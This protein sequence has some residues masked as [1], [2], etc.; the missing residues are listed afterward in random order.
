MQRKTLFDMKLFG[1]IGRNEADSL[2]SR[3]VAEAR[4]KQSIID[5]I[6]AESLDRAKAEVSKWRDAL[7]QWED[8]KQP[9]RYE[10]MQLYA[11]IIQ[12]DSVATHL[13]T[14]VRS[15]EGT[16]FQVGIEGKDGIVPDEKKAEIF[17]GEW[18]EEL[19]RAIIEAE[20]M[21][22]TLIEI[23]PPKGGQ[24][25]VDD[26]R[27]VPRY[28][29][30]P[31]FKQ[32][33]TKPQVFL[34]TLNYEDPIFAPRLIK[35]GDRYSKGLF[36]SLVLIYI[37]KKNAMAYWSNFQ[38]KFGIP[39]VIVKT[40]LSDGKKVNSLTYFMQNMRSNTFSL[41]GYDDTVEVL[42]NVN[43]DAFQTFEHLVRHCDEQIAKVLE[44]QTMTANDG[45]S[46]SQAE[47][48][49]RIA[50][51]FHQARLRRVER[52]INSQV[53]PIIRQDLPGYEGMMFRFAERKNADE[54]IDRAVKLKQAG[55]Q[56]DKAYLEEVTGMTLTEVQPIPSVQPQSVINAIDELYAQALK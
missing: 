45:S 33:R 16:E 30:I 37:Y 54:V 25:T 34:N 19:I 32:V 52:I 6:Q 24:Y 23:T 4:K 50:E 26:I 28:M 29:V 56:V 48:H 5:S 49:E 12:D 1:L 8:E 22:F 15:I 17:K 31:E 20:M 47:V 2:I 40:D 42:S 14:I 44:G 13:T 51:E 46:R 39:P 38:S 41:V 27:V 36:N 53:M 9:D 55:Y 7:E 21:G 10:M 18:Y 35:V 3:A 43:T 11:E